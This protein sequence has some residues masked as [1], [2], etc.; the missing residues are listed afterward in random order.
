MSSTAVYGNSEISIS[1]DIEAVP[2]KDSGIAVLAAEKVVQDYYRKN[3][4]KYPKENNSKII[5]EVEH[6][7]R[8][9]S[10]KYRE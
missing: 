7:I 6:C 8:K 9:Y 1:E 5:K 10:K 3:L 4:R 2:V